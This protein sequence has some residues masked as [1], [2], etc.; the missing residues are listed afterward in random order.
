MKKKLG[1]LLLSTLLITTMFQGNIIHATSAKS[2]MQVSFENGF[3]SIQTNGSLTDEEKIKSLLEN[4]FSV[5]LDDVK[6]HKTYDFSPCF[7]DSG[8]SKTN[9]NFFTNKIKYTSEVNKFY[10]ADILSDNLS[11]KFDDIK[12]SDNTADIKLFEDYKYLLS[13]NN[14]SN[15]ETV[16][17]YTIKMQKSKNKWLISKIE[18]D[19]SFDSAYK[20]KNLDVSTMISALKNDS[21]LN[22]PDKRELE[23]RKSVEN[24]SVA[25]L[26]AQWTQTLYNRAVAGNYAATYSIAYNQNFSNYIPDDCQNF[27]SQCVW[28]GFGGTNSGIS[29]KAFPMVSS[30]TRA[31]Y[32]TATKYDTP[33]SWVWTGVMYFAD[34]INNGGY[35]IGVGPYGWINS[36]VAYAEVGD[37]IQVS[38]NNNSTYDHTMVVN[39]VTGTAGSRG[40]SDI[41]I[42]AHTS[43]CVNKRLDLATGM[44]TGAH[45]TVKINGYWQN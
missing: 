13:K 27:A 31:W 41:W 28:A 43:D 45:R 4:F 26:S 12:I 39:A 15:S 10:S 30:G 11:L 37:I 40:L 16:T 42:S 6:S 19:D 34:Y 35:Q 23:Y 22:I 20:N 29:S 7:Y 5:K 14:G 1:V 3:N 32:Q 36:G 8:E 2:D 17:R 24:I 38:W 21:K 9:Q 33:T 18:S 25:P 44:S